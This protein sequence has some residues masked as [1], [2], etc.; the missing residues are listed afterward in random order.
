M[1]NRYKTS[2]LA[3]FL[4]ITALLFASCGEGTTGRLS[5][6]EVETIEDYL[7]SS[8]FILRGD[9]A[10][11]D[12]R[13][14]WD[15]T[16]EVLLPTTADATTTA[17][18]N[19]YPEKGQNTNV[20]ITAEDLGNLVFKVVNV[21]TYPRQD[22]IINTTE[23]YYIKDD[24]DGY[25]DSG[26]NICI[27]DGTT[28]SNYRIKFE[29]EYADGS[30]RYEKVAA[31]T[32][33][34]STNVQY[35]AFDINGDLVFPSGITYTP[36][37]DTDA[38]YSSMVNYVQVYGDPLN[39]YSDYTI[40]V[41]TRYYTE[42]GDAAKPTKTSVAYERTFTREVAVQ[43]PKD[44]ISAFSLNLFS[45]VDFVMKASETVIRYEIRPNG[46]K[47]VKTKTQLL[48]EITGG[49]IVTFTANY[50]TDDSGTVI[51]SGAPVAVY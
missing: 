28:N 15:Y 50:E 10:L 49:S 33:D 44:K 27:A 9:T 16:K 13:S 38:N 34:G 30:I 46:K 17:K 12:S 6:D 7:M 18:S 45:G 25:L 26:D 14:A 23:S 39:F 40:I 11:P 21:T 22:A 31:N 47:T 48:D 35:A 19:N 41:G 3:I 5:T 4:V 2:L 8:Y 51:S 43:N 29:T 32:F 1:T 42:H 24:G 36:P 37:S 20:T